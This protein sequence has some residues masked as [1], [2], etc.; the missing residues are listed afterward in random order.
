MRLAFIVILTVAACG[1]SSEPHANAGESSSKV[2]VE[3][4]AAADIVKGAEDILSQPAEP[5]TERDKQAA[6]APTALVGT[7]RI[8]HLIYIKD[9]APGKPDEPLMDGTWIFDASGHFQKRGGNEVDGTFVL[10]K[11][12][13]VVSGLGPTLEY[14]VD[15]LTATELVVTQ[16]IM[17]GMGT[18]V[19]LER[20][21]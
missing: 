11:T 16:M 7:W 1:R 17:P 10:T 2:A 8:K 15:K 18:S 13:L 12:A 14:S 9:G 4:K 3:A 21:K 19:V 20:V 6:V 5:I